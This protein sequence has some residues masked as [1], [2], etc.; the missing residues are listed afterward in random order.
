ME[1][2]VLVLLCC[3]IIFTGNTSTWPKFF[4]FCFI[5]FHVVPPLVFVKKA[6][7]WPKESLKNVFFFESSNYMI[8]SE[9]WPKYCLD[10]S[11]KA[12]SCMNGTNIFKVKINLFENIL[13]GVKASW[14]ALPFIT[15]FI[16]IN[17]RWFARVFHISNLFAPSVKALTS[18][19][20]QRPARHGSSKIKCFRWLCTQ[21]NGNGCRI[22]H[23]W[24]EKSN[25]NAKFFCHIWDGCKVSISNGAG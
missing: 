25:D 14:K 11:E 9:H 10:V 20:I 5:V 22:P 19:E 1:L 12:I 17:I 3:A 24:S 8:F 4:L 7:L 2:C 18:S 16:L 13:R 23:V 6:I 21:S 15:F